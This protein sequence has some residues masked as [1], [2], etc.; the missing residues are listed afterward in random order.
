V[1]SILSC[2]N[3]FHFKPTNS[4]CTKP[5]V[6]TSVVSSRYYFLIQFQPNWFD[7]FSIDD[8]GAILT[9]LENLYTSSLP[10]YVPVLKKILGDVEPAFRKLGSATV[11]TVAF[12]LNKYDAE[13]STR[14]EIMNAL[15]PLITTAKLDKLFPLSPSDLTGQPAAPQGKLLLL[16]PFCWLFVCWLWLFARAVILAFVVCL[17]VC[18][19]CFSVECGSER[20]LFLLWLL[21][22]FCWLFAG[23]VFVVVVVI[24]VCVACDSGGVLFLLWVLCSFCW[25]FTGWVLFGVIVVASMAV[26]SVLV[27]VAFCVLVVCC[28]IGCLLFGYG[29]LLFLSFLCCLQ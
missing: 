2:V 13:P 3:R 27:V 19:G 20:V 7:F 23:C 16:C 24:C 14:R 29:C 5:I 10:N 22:P 11:D 21:C 12:V 9:N 26:L 25:L 8:S 18:Y 28:S 17:A 15:K 1:K 6:C 4:Y